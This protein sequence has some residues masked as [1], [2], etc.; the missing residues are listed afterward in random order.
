MGFGG[1]QVVR[2]TEG[3][4]TFHR[5]RSLAILMAIIVLAAIPAGYYI[6]NRH[7]STDEQEF[8]ET[9]ETSRSTHRD[10]WK[11]HK[12]ANH[13]FPMVPGAIAI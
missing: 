13:Q 3:P 6:A 10:L 1:N 7:R 4:G 12:A 11:D 8:P 9:V 5:T 2:S